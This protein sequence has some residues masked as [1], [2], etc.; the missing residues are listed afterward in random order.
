MSVIRNNYQQN[1]KDVDTV[2]I[3]KGPSIG[4]W[5]FIE[6]AGEVIQ[7][8]KDD[9]QVPDR[10]VIRT[11]DLSKANMY[12][13]SLGDFNRW[14]HVVRN[15]GFKAAFYDNVCSYPRNLRYI[16][17]ENNAVGLDL[18]YNFDAHRQEYISLINDIRVQYDD[19]NIVGTS[20]YTQFTTTEDVT[21]IQDFR[22]W[23]KW[24]AAA[25]PFSAIDEVNKQW[26]AAGKI[27]V[28]VDEAG[29][30]RGDNGRPL[31]SRQITSCKDAVENAAAA[32]GLSVEYVTGE[33]NNGESIC[34]LYYGAIGSFEA[35]GLS[36]DYA[37]GLQDLSQNQNH[38]VIYWL[39]DLSVEAPHL[40]MRQVIN[41]ETGHAFGLQ[42][43]P[44]TSIPSSE[45]IMGFNFVEG[46]KV[47]TDKDKSDITAFW[48]NV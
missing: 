16:R 13:D 41:H 5:D 38:K 17:G 43:P 30:W 27:R 36:P 10:V 33:L 14:A 11:T 39:S 22:N 31:T 42:H 8:A 34:D 35:W 19:Y 26:K 28:F 18:T 20:V 15:K 29:A 32:A 21:H 3:A 4:T 1:W 25:G 23:A 46:Y 40:N 6:I 7:Y 9:P 12:F 45:T 44:N 47:L 37:A 48:A 24:A 2:Y